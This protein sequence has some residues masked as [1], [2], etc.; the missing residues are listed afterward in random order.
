M[1]RITDGDADG[2]KGAEPTPSVG[3]APA[4]GGRFGVSGSAEG[5][6]GGAGAA[7][8]LA[9]RSAMG[10]RSAYKLVLGLHLK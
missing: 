5:A 7:E 4:W 2:L 3:N 10:E 1:S 8:Y 6:K 9:R